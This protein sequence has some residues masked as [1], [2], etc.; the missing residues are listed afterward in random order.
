[1]DG[2]TA[3]AKTSIAAMK[4]RKY[5]YK[6]E[7]VYWDK[8]LKNFELQKD[9]LY[10]TIFFQNAGEFIT[11]TVTFNPD[12]TS[13]TSY[14]FKLPGKDLWDTLTKVVAIVGNFFE[15]IQCSMKWIFGTPVFL[16]NAGDRLGNSK[17]ELPLFGP[18]RFDKI[19]VAQAIVRK[20]K[21]LFIFFS[22]TMT[23]LRYVWEFI[24]PP[25]DD[26]NLSFLQSLRV[27]YSWDNKIKFSEHICKF[28][29]SLGKMILIGAGAYYG[30][31]GMFRRVDLTTQVASQWKFIAK[32]EIERADRLAGR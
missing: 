29:S 25:V 4:W 18:T 32:K 17:V 28:I 7:E 19:P 3:L 9:L 13:T 30:E 2:F 15:L 31:T 16:T 5:F 1:L 10:A 20:P 12:G 6:S 21:D 26:P 23:V 27:Q 24:L 14:S 22:D 8:A 11:K